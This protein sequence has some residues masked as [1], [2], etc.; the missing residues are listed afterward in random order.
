MILYWI[1]QRPSTKLCKDENQV[2]L[3]NTH[4]ENNL[5]SHVTTAIR[6]GEK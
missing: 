5:Q 2:N 4:K 3:K 6:T 1:Q